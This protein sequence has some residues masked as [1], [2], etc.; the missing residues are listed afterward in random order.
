MRSSG[1]PFLS[2]VTMGPRMRITRRVNGAFQVQPLRL[3]HPYT[4]I[5][6]AGEPDWDTRL[7][8]GTC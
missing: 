7:V 5:A 1:L 8:T 2:D 4:N 3:D 6:T